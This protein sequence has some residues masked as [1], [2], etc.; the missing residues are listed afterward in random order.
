MDH[1]PARAAVPAA[2]P[3]TSGDHAHST[4]DE[5]DLQTYTTF[6]GALRGYDRRQVN[7]YVTRT[8]RRIEELT[9]EL[10][11]TRR[12]QQVLATRVDELG[13]A[14]A[15]CTCDPNKPES[16]VV[17]ARLR[18]IIEIATTE[19]DDLR[20]R[21]E[22]ETR[23]MREEAE[24][25]LRDA[26]QQ[27]EQATSALEAM[28]AHRRAAE[29]AAVAERRAAIEKWAERHVSE[30]RETARRV[31]ERA[32][33]VSG[34]VIASARWLVDALGAHRDALS[35]QL[36]G[37]QRRIDGL[38]SLEAAAA[39]PGENLT[40]LPKED[41]PAPD[42]SRD[43]ANQ[44]VRAVVRVPTAAA[45]ADEPPAADRRE[46]RSRGGAHAARPA[47]EPD[48]PVPAQPRVHAAPAEP[49]PRGA[50]GAPAEPPARRGAH[51][52]PEPVAPDGVVPTPPGGGVLLPPP[53]GVAAVPPPPSGGVAVPASP[54][55]PAL[56][57]LPGGGVA[58]PASPGG[59]ALPAP[60]GGPALPAP[61]GGPALPAPPGRGAP[62]APSGNAV[63]PGMLPPAPAGALPPAPPPDAAALNRTWAPVNPR[64]GGAHRG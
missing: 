11:T 17:G 61:P 57:A 9:S 10:T 54:G 16:A 52:A 21:T 19:A 64:I 50:H 55:G 41:F 51:A 60:P 29:E 58:V 32:A 48:T 49:A 63:L 47:D 12:S 40:R 14:S 42:V 53:T 24:A 31:I 26:R 8:Q 62:P 37:V 7:K 3:E 30:A 22:T 39:V 44:P 25:Y 33:A 18:Q 1:S 15:M 35:E 23:A 2:A 6:D 36:G 46:G 59:P 28:L 38:P 43:G 4:G 20:T 5:A 45:M 56:P 13:K 34:Q 27:A